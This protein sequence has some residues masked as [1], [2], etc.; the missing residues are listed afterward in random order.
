MQ[1]YY[2]KRFLDRAKLML[3]F[4]WGAQKRSIPKNSGKTV[5]FNRFSPLAVATT[6]LTEATLP[7]G[8]DMT[9]T[10]VSATVAEYGDYTK[11]GSLFSLT[12]IDE[13]LG[14]HM[15]VLGQQAGETVDTLIVA[16]LSAG[17][18][19]QLAGG[20]S[21]ITAVAASDT[22]TGA[23]IRKAVRTLKTNKAMRFGDGMFHGIVQPFTSY[24]LFGNSE[25]LNTVIYTDPTQL[26]E[27]VI[28]KLHGVVFKESNNSTSEAST[29]TVYHNFIFGQNAYG[30]VDVAGSG[31]AKTYVKTS[32]PQDTS[33]PIPRFSTVGWQIDA[34]VA[35]TL[36]ANWI[37]NLKAGASA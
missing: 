30:I 3:T 35:K 28:G 2:D 22:L 20:K 37:L 27:G 26:K 7:A 4:D 36:N 25:W 6:P 14:E 19:V 34:F 24:D 17:A 12:S 1:I 15:D 9:T 5:Y 8:K 23:E 31:N 33:Q 18:T 29:V 21:N 11:V 16:E 13:G 10:I 32:G